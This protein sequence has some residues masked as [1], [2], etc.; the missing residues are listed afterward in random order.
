MK[1]IRSNYMVALVSN[2][3]KAK[4][5]EQLKCYTVSNYDIFMEKG[6]DGTR[7][8]YIQDGGCVDC[9]TGAAI[10]IITDVIN[11]EKKHF[12][13]NSIIYYITSKKKEQGC[14]KS[15]ICISISRTI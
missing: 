14:M 8:L 2:R 4:I 9:I 13:I 11:E 1:A 7:R 5:E 15:T 3:M 6:D 10:D 12:E